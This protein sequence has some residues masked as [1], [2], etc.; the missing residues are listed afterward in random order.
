RRVCGELR[1]QVWRRGEERGSDLGRVEVVEVD[2]LGQKLLRRVDDRLG[3]VG[4][5]RRGAA[6]PP[7]RQAFNS[8]L[9]SATPS[10]ARSISS[11]I[12]LPT[13]AA[14]TLPRNASMCAWREM[15]KTAAHDRYG[16]RA[17]STHETVAHR[18]TYE[19]RGERQGR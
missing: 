5:R 14:S 6:D 9:T 4:G 1:V 2:E 17:T 11:T 19:D 15:P 3:C 16:S 13:A 12:A 18:G 10:P 8:S 7:Y